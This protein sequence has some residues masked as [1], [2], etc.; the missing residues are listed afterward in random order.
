MVDFVLSLNRPFL[1]M[2]K[3]LS[4][5]L[6]KPNIFWVIIGLKLFVPKTMSV[7][8]LFSPRNFSHQKFSDS[9]FVEPIIFFDPE[10][11]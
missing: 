7:T 9:I 8:H 1:L 5:D 4:K 6:W 10:V 2:T 3:T 11:F